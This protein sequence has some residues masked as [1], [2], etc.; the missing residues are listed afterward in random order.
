MKLSGVVKSKMIDMNFMENQYQKQ[1]SVDALNILA[2][3]MSTS[4]KIAGITKLAQPDS[5]TGFTGIDAM[6]AWNIIHN[7]QN[8]AKQGSSG[9]GGDK[10]AYIYGMGAAQEG[11]LTP[12]DKLKYKSLLTPEQYAR[13]DVTNNIAV[14]R[15]KD[16]DYKTL[17]SEVKQEKMEYTKDLMGLFPRDKGLRNLLEADYMESANNYLA[18]KDKDTVEKLQRRKLNM[19]GWAKKTGVKNAARQLERITATGIYPEAKPTAKPNAKPT[20]RFTVKEV[21]K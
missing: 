8:E 10:I 14:E 20:N 19:L 7:L 21:K 5:A 3:N 17:V 9:G 15:E 4:Q 11:K 1:K 2:S 13:M 6:A 18:A 12:Q 16:A